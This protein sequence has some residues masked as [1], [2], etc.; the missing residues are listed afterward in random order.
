M[1]CARTPIFATLLLISVFW[2]NNLA[3]AECVLLLHGL[4]RTSES[5]TAMQKTLES[6]GFE[7]HNINYPS[8][9]APIEHLAH[10]AITPALSH[11]KNKKVHF[12]THSMGGILVREYL[13]AQNEQ[14]PAAFAIGR[15][16]MLGPPN[17][18][19]EVV[20]TFAN[21]KA[22][23]WINGPAGLQLGTT[24]KPVALGAVN[25]ELGII[26]GNRSFN[27]ILSNVLPGPDDGKV[28]VART[29]VEGEKEHMVLPVTHTFMMNNKDVQHAVVSFLKRGSFQEDAAHNS[30][31]EP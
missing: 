30:T 5:M 25:F 8:R 2:S 22:F 6:A 13:A 26:A 7:T 23:E 28:S 31:S 9:S 19:S 4:A 29:H 1:N 3:A 15:V 17:Q 12:V 16:V 14:S 20:D 10:E 18:G 21:L 24:G 27:P 11:C